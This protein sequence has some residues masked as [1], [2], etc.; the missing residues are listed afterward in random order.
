MN[1]QTTHNRTKLYKK[2]IPLVLLITASSSVLTSQTFAANLVA[3][4]AFPAVFFQDTD[5]G[6]GTDDWVIAGGINTTPNAFFRIFNNV[7][8]N[9][10]IVLQIN[11]ALSGN[12]T[13][14]SIKVES[15]GDIR[16][17][18]NSVTIDRS[19][20]R[21]GIG[22]TAPTDELTINAFTPGIRFNDTST[23]ANAMDFDL[24]VNENTFTLE[25]SVGNDLVAVTTTPGSANSRN[26]LVVDTSGDISL[27][28]G[29]VFIDRST[30][31]VGI[32][33]TSPNGSLHIED[34]S[35]PEIILKNVPNGSEWEIEASTNRLSMQENG[36]AKFIVENGASS[37]SLVIDGTSNIGMGTT[38]PESALHI[39]R[40]NA[41]IKIED[42]NTVA[43]NR[44]LIELENNGGIGVRFRNTDANAIWDFNNTNSG[45]FT[46]SKKN[47]GGFEFEVQGNGRTKVRSFGTLIM[48]MRAD[49]NLLIPTGDVIVAGTTLNVPDYVF[50]HDYQLMPLDEL[51]TFVKKN[52]HL[53][54]VASE[55]EIKKAKQLS[56]AKSHMKHLEKI[57]ELTLYTIE[58]HEQIKSLKIENEF[59]KTQL[60]EKSAALKEKD[61]LIQARLSSLE[62]L[63]T[64]LAS[65]GNLLPATGAKAVLMKK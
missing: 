64:N 12:L 9:N 60:S 21:I 20:N 38:T 41:A 35:A 61:D 26:S 58:Q 50:E 49:G 25:D 55:A 15:N 31:R 29:D 27:A 11:T 56:M 62:K 57:E 22:T 34:A 40:D 46:V 14:N 59:V 3:S 47:S 37:G 48:D 17:A 19:T 33:T 8:T 52:K 44:Q 36:V 28:D 5:N 6:T 7:G 13:G 53:P 18:N 4:S 16:L 65:S 39:Q 30:S 54:N 10:N 24:T 63:V 42:T 32:G 51:K 43:A 45:N 23:T 1:K 2:I